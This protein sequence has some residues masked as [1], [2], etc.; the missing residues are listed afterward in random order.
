MRPLKKKRPY[1]KASLHTASKLRNGT[2][3][4][5]DLEAIETPSRNTNSNTNKK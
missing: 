1:P 4:Q 3:P 2:P 5:K